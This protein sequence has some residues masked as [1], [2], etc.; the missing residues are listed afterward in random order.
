MLYGD[1][2][3]G[4]FVIFRFVRSSDEVRCL[5]VAYCISCGYYFTDLMA[6][7]NSLV[8]ECP[9]APSY[10]KYL[11]LT[12]NIEFSPATQKRRL[13]KNDSFDT[14]VI[15]SAAPPAIVSTWPFIHPPS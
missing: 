12:Y 14:G 1:E 10:T 15:Y 8:N 13:R 4:G 5:V 9:M 6:R 11:I 3:R 2:L 7:D